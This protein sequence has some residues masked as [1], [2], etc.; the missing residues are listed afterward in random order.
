MKKEIRKII[1]KVVDNLWKDFDLKLEEIEINRAPEKFGDYSTNVAMKLAG[2]LG[3]SPMEI[4]EKMQKDI[5][6]NSLAQDWIEKMEVVK[7]GF[8]NFYFNQKAFKDVLKNVLKE[9]DKY[10]FLDLKKGQKVMVEF[11]Q[12]NT[13]K[14]ITV[15]HLK[16]A[17]SGLAMVKIFENLGAEVI[18]ANFFGDVGMHVAKSTW[19]MM[20]K[21]IPADFDDWDSV[22][23]MKFIDKSYVEGARAFEEDPEAEKEIRKI[24]RDIYKKEDNE[25]YQWYQKIRDWSIEHQDSF[26]KEIGIE[27]DRQ[28]PESEIYQEAIEI[29]NQYR[30]KI[31][32]ESQGAVIYEGEKEGLNNWVFLTSEGNPT[33]SAKDL[34]LANKKF[35]EY[36]LDLAIVTTSVEQTDYFKAIIKILEKI[37][38]NFV[39]RYK[40]IPFGWL[41]MDGKKTSSRMGKTAKAMDILNEAKELAEKQIAT[42]KEYSLEEKKEIVGKVALGGLKFMILSREFHK[43]INYD[44]EEFIKLNGFSGPFIMY[45]YVRINSIV[46]KSG[47][48]DLSNLDDLKF[49]NKYE[50]QLSSALMMY[51][52]TV[53]RV[54][55]EIAPHLMCVYLYEVAQKFNGFYENCPIQ[56]AENEIQK[57]SRLV[58]AKATG[59]V[60]KNGLALLGIDVLERM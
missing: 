51:K 47:K 48:V 5:L 17:I 53:T 44:P 15:G 19:G 10:G 59:Q 28:Y 14:A 25:N 18:K 20:Q 22:E 9:G 34:A 31:F 39:G 57:K 1:L 42:D 55:E 36:D 12:P 3:K 26:F 16:S 23:K 58:L 49:E 56:G 52:D 54:G 21:E 32:T 6:E 29:V 50:K 43:D 41:L 60:L 40:H 8:V 45:S 11:G 46:K 7:P 24:N 4:A 2:K 38:Q 30:D 33:Y 37:D 35:E 27:Y 13:H